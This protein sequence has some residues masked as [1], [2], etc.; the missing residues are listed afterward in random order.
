MTIIT[1]NPKSTSTLSKPGTGEEYRQKRAAF[2]DAVALQPSIHGSGSVGYHARLKEIYQFHVAPGQKVLEIGCGEGD[3][4][5]AVQP[6]FGL[7][8]D[9]SPSMIQRARRKH[10][11]LEF[12]VADGHVFTFPETFDIVILSDL[13]NDAWDVQ[14]LLEQL[15][16]V[17]LPRTRIILNYYSRLWSPVLTTAGLLHLAQKTLEQN[18]LTNEDVS[19]LL[20]LSGFEVIRRIPEVSLPLPVPVLGGF[21]NRFLVR[22]WPFNQL[23]LSNLVIARPAPVFPSIAHPREPLVTVVIP[24]R[25]EEGNI[26]Q[27]FTRVPRM[28]AGVELVFVEGH[29]KD[30]TQA[31]IARQIESHPEVNARLLCQTGKGKGDAVR[32]GFKHARG[33]VLM[34]LD[35]DL[36]VPPESLPR[37]YNA[38]VEGK[39]DFING[40]RLVYPMEKKAMRFFNFL[41][42]KFFSIAFRWLLGQP[43]KDTLCG[44]KVLW[45]QDYMKI[46]KNR[47]YFGEFD[48]FGDYD[49]LFGAAKL[50]LRIVDLPIRYEDRTYGTT[51]IQRWK[52]GWVL[53]KMVVLAALRLKF[54]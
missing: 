16:A 4:L 31:E 28:G 41:G 34:I 6:T 5:A 53:L 21:L 22:V 45:K 19:N 7:G 3:L 38:L 2:W 44:T 29:S 23:A 1:E 32:L 25:N 47:S 14:Q 24:A 33:D 15:H 30:N 37:F 40:V 27:I 43:V 12:G 52:H 49:L 20:H 51:N 42:N 10:P 13:L 11:D 17:V 8:I 48:P 46:E 9:L 39:G 26:A 36:T 35:A 18:W 50:N 54:I